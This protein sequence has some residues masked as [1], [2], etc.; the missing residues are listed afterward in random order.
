M[1]KEQ[2]Q[3]KA[4]DVSRALLGMSQTE[5]IDVLGMIIPC[6]AKVLP[7]VV[8][9]IWNVGTSMN[10]AKAEIKPTKTG[11]GLYFVTKRGQSLNLSEDCL[12]KV[13]E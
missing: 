11:V 6:N 9:Y 5:I 7:A 12:G 2:L 3:I 10:A 4:A 8:L 1:T 13:E